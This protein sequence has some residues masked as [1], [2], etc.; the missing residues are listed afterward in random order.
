MPF[1]SLLVCELKCPKCNQL[2][3][4]RFVF[5]WGL[6]GELYRMPENAIRWARHPD[7]RPV[8]SYVFVRGQIN[9][10]QPDLE[11]AWLT[12]RDSFDPEFGPYKCNHCGAF[13][14]GVVAMVR[15]GRLSPPRVLISGDAEAMFKLPPKQLPHAFGIGQTTPLYDIDA[16]V[17]G[18]EWSSD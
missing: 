2:L 14:E 4:D 5:C 13:I 6:S 12:D 8:G 18:T 9:M 16:R 1:N 17:T 11:P 7:G 15:E 3:F 10:G